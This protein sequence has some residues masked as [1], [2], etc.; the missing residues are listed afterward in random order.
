MDLVITGLLNKEIAY[1]PGTGEKTIKAHRARMMQKMQATSVAQLVR[2]A[3]VERCEPY[4]AQLQPI[5]V[6]INCRTRRGG[7]RGRPS[8]PRLR[9]V[10]HSD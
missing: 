6:L 8:G 3:M 2:M 10:A 5:P 7:V 1:T 9:H 4:P